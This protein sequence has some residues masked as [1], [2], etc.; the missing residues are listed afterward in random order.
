MWVIPERCARWGSASARPTPT[1]WL[2]DSTALACRPWRSRLTAPPRCADKRCSIWRPGGSTSCSRSTC[3]TRGSTCRPSTRSCCFGRPRARC[4]SSSSS[5]A[6]CGVP[7]GKAVCTVLDF[8]GMHRKEF[9]FDRRFRALL[10]GSRRDVQRQIEEDFPFLPSGCSLELDRR[11]ARSSCGAFARPFRRTGRASAQSWGPSVTCRSRRISTRP[12]S[13]SRTCTPGS[14]TWTDL[15]RAVNLP[16]APAGSA[17]TALLRAVSRWLHVDDLER[18]DAYRNLVGHER[19]PLEADL[20]RV[21]TPTSA[22]AGWWPHHEA[23]VRARSTTHCASSGSIPRYGPELLE[24]LDLLPGRVDHLHPPIGI[25]G[26]PLAV[27][28]RY[29]RSEILAAFASAPG[30]DLETGVWW[31]A[32][33]SPTCSRSRSTSRSF[34]PTTRYRDYAINREL[35]HW[36]SQSATALDSPRSAVHRQ[37]ASGTNVVL[38]ARLSTQTAV[39]RPGDLRQ[40]PGRTPD[41]DHLA[42]APP[43]ARRP[44]RPVRGG[45]RIDG[46]TG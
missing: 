24:L 44:V 45:R 18:I 28:A 39:L 17:E 15:R 11:P 27:H 40:P 12:V 13:S 36:E 6:V 32:S 2:S 4:C 8:V 38:F 46:H 31:D 19:P 26:V 37:A 7:D 5:A 25:D 23:D 16:T 9:R 34:S 41:R 1:S 35:V 33:S 3:S 30:A 20:E 42:A 43:V 29:T 21:G 14:R 22:D 10:G